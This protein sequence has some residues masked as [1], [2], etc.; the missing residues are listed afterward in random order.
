[1]RPERFRIRQGFSAIQAAP[2]TLLTAT[3]VLSAPITA[4]QFSAAAPVAIAVGALGF[5]LTASY[6]VRRARRRSTELADQAY[7]QMAGMRA[8][9]DL[10]TGILDG[11]SE[12][13]I[14]W[15]DINAAPA[16]YGQSD[17]L[18]PRGAELSDVAAFRHWLTQTDAALLASQVSALKNEARAF[19]TSLVTLEGRLVRVSGRLIGGAA[20]L[21]ARPATAQPETGDAAAPAQEPR[22]DLPAALSAEILFDLFALP[23]WL[24]NPDGTLV[25]ANAAYWKLAEAVGA[26][27]DPGDIPELLA[28]GETRSMLA[29]LA[30]T[31][32]PLEFERDLPGYAGYSM[33]LFSTDAGTGGFLR[34]QAE[35]AAV[36][37]PVP[38]MEAAVGPDASIIDAIATPIAIFDG[39]KRLRHFNKAYVDFWELDSD[40]L[41]AG[42]DEPAILDRLRTQGQLPSEADY[43]AWRARHLESYTLTAPREEP[44]YL[45]DGRTLNVVSVP[46]SATSG[47]IYIFEDITERLALESKYNALIEVQGETLGAL[48]EGVA[49]FGTNGRLTLHNRR[50][51]ELWKLPMNELG[52]HPHIDDVAEA[53]AQT[54]PDDGATIWSDLKQNVVDLNPARTDRSGRITRADGRMIDYA[55]TRLPDGQTMMTFVDVTESANYQR[56]LKERNDALVTADRLKDAFV[57]N[58]SYELRSPL[59]NI[60]GFADLLASETA[61]DLNEKQRA[62]TDYIRASSQTLG[63]LID[64]IL[65]LA[66]ADAG[67]AELRLEE[68]DVS[69]LVE[70]ARAGLVGTLTSGGSE[71]PPNLV[72][73]IDD[74]LPTFTADGTRIVQVLYNLLSNAT[75][76]SAPGT[77]VRL[78]VSSRAGRIVFTVEDEGVGISEEM[79]AALFQRFEGRSSEGRQRGA[80]LGLAIVKTFV[81]LHGGTVSL[82][83]REPKGTRV[84]VSIPADPGEAVSAAE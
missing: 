42:L 51:S 62:Y 28:R 81:S 68:Q 48:S 61:G 16:I 1:M 25:Y 82:E 14:V 64:N 11:L 8:E 38:P 4:S 17:I 58:V 19:D 80:G 72:V 60:I 46:S 84:I 41:Q 57:Q 71:T 75:R 52:K 31:S 55:V 10:A 5:G 6:M 30:E 78:G 63:V 36:P 32:G 3:P 54:M 7:Q 45:P 73:S 70:R 20:V 83:R 13:T 23:A 76:F 59:T 49:V 67:V 44:W 26:K 34:P 53:C 2:L 79:K 43:R 27:N 33:L 65:D 56:V 18:L 35:Q 15:R 29:R 39:D 9:L 40:W 47:V 66:T 77:E 69:R 24:R 74:D 21:R 50:L 37:A 22:R 12:V